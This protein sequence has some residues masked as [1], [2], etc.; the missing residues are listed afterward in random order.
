[1]YCTFCGANEASESICDKCLAEQDVDNVIKHYFHRGYPYDAI[2]GLLNKKE[3]LHMCVRTLKRHLKSLGLRRK[4]N[5]R[6]I[7][8]STVRTAI[9]EE[10][11]GPGGLS[12]YRSI[13]HALRLRHHIHVPRKLVAEIMKEIDPVGVEERRSR[14]LKRRTFNSKGANDSWHMDGKSAPFFFQ[15]I[16]SNEK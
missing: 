12:G 11:R 3:G 2:V 6:M 8:D 7:D 5:A 13:W 14:R 4:G 15:S 16:R 1:M 10:M 9:L